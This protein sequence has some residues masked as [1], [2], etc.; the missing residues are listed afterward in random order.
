MRLLL[1]DLCERRRGHRNV[2]DEEVEHAFAEMDA[3][4]NGEVSLH[5]FSAF[6]STTA[7][8]NVNVMS[9]HGEVAEVTSSAT[10]VPRVHAQA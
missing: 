10:R 9:R 4:G 1:Q 5:E 8:S 2:S 3:D 6:L 7:L